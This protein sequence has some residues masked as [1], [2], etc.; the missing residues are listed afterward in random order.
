MKATARPASPSIEDFAEDP[1]AFLKRLRDRD[2]PE[3]LSVD[4]QPEAVVI[5]LRLAEFLA[6]CDKRDLH[7][8]LELRI[9]KLDSGEDEGIPVEQVF[10]ELR[11][12]LAARNLKKI[13]KHK[14]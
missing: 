5:D 8:V 11:S 12:E 3:L 2:M 10:R 1:Q 6:Q 9:R 7:E 4:G 14:P 13:G